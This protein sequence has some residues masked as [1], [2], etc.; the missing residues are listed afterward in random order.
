MLTKNEKQILKPLLEECSDRLSNKTCNDVKLPN[1][2]ENRELLKQMYIWN[3]RGNLEEYEKEYS[4]QIKSYEKTNLFGEP[5]KQFIYT[6]D[7]FVFDY[8]MS[9]LGLKN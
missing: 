9:K 3:V 2:A 6:Q 4:K 7:W 1:T 5:E 8:L